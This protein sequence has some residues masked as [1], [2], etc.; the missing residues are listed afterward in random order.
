M[1]Q[2]IDQG[3]KNVEISLQKE[4]EPFIHYSKKGRVYGHKCR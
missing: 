4:G 3:K 2:N 1:E